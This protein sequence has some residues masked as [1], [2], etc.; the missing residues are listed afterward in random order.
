MKKFLSLLVFTLC[1]FIANAHED[2]T[3]VSFDVEIDN[4]VIGGVPANVFS[5]YEN[6]WE[7]VRSGFIRNFGYGINLRSSSKKSKYVAGANLN[8]DIILHVVNIV[9]DNGGDATAEAYITDKQ[10]NEL[11]S[12]VKISGDGDSESEEDYL[13]YDNATT[14]KF[15][16]HLIV[17]AFD[18]GD[19][20]RKLLDKVH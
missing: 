9:I 3:L 5:T 20:A 10:G 15:L 11:A 18:M 2:V 19:E 4:A 7:E 8:S 6:R 16:K 1:S 14:S 13:Y 12:R 17:A